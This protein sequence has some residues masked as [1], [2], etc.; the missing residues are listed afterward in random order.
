MS[1]TDDIGVG[2]FDS[3]IVKKEKP[4][5]YRID[6][7]PKKNEELR[8]EAKDAEGADY[9]IKHTSLESNDGMVTNDPVF[10]YDSPDWINYDNLSVDLAALEYWHDN[11]YNYAKKEKANPSWADNQAAIVQETFDQNLHLGTYVWAH[12]TDDFIIWD[13]RAKALRI[14]YYGMFKV[15][16]LPVIYITQK[17]LDVQE[18][19]THRDENS[20]PIGKDGE[21]IDYM[22]NTWHPIR[23]GLTE[24]EAEN[25]G[26]DWTPYS[27]PDKETF[28]KKKK[29]AESL[30]L[31][32]ASSGWVFV[33]GKEDIGL[34]QVAFTTEYVKSFTKR[35]RNYHRD[36][37]E[38]RELL[39]QSK[40]L[41]KLNNLE[42]VFVVYGTVDKPKFAK[43]PG[44]S[45][46]THLAKK[47][48]HD[49]RGKYNDF[50]KFLV[51]EDRYQKLEELAEGLRPISVT[52]SP[53]ALY[54]TYQNH[55]SGDDITK[56]IFDPY[57]T[58]YEEP[59]R[60]K[61]FI[62]P[63]N[64]TYEITTIN[65][66]YRKKAHKAT[67]FLKLEEPSGYVYSTSER[68]MNSYA[69]MMIKYSNKSLNKTV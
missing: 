13:G 33:R 7:F 58:Y 25:S 32:M 20:Y 48:E 50:D 57:I 65:V 41:G 54:Q 23:F 2:T 67:I 39:N 42:D 21:K 66:T 5:A 37:F 17:L 24:E 22:R 44:T 28:T 40:V 8:E 60:F 38:F 10:E 49:R 68:V 69:K 43:I 1:A 31:G 62:D 61:G 53:E 3:T 15:T 59:N 51:D 26:F 11:D 55:K 46:E 52:V 29:D 30:I 4:V 9:L 19:R 34:H 16:N 18:I 47:I 45:N 27:A 63:D 14:P 36:E 35:L 6:V 56:S 64:E 12:G